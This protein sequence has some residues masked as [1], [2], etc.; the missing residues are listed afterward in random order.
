MDEKDLK[1][2]QRIK[3]N[4]IAGRITGTIIA[5]DYGRRVATIARDDGQG[6]YGKMFG[7]SGPPIMNGWYVRF[8]KIDE[9]LSDD[10][11]STPEVS[12]EYP[13]EMMPKL[14]A[15]ARK[16]A[17]SGSCKG[18]VCQ[19]CPS[20]FVYHEYFSCDKRSPS[21]KTNN[22]NKAWFLAFVEI[23]GE[24]NHDETHH[25]LHILESPTQGIVCGNPRRGKPP[26]SESVAVRRKRMLDRN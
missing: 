6:H 5:L 11:P 18:I 15:S 3:E 4:S 12:G 13:V 21:G 16:I 14:L 17:A 8:D 9:V 24:I 22:L 23:Y 20:S 7:Y 26:R 19:D 25:Y 1:L 10:P 2:G